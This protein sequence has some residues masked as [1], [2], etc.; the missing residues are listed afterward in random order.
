MRCMN[1][2]KVKIA[3]ATVAVQEGVFQSEISKDIQELID[4]TWANPEAHRRRD[5]L[6][7]KGKPTPTEF[8]ATL[9]SVYKESN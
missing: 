1:I 3:M 9:V 8:I 5:E 2:A 4:A 6:F 7:P